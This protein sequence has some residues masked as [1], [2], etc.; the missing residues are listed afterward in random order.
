M[1]RAAYEPEPE[2]GWAPDDDDEDIFGD[3]E[4]DEDDGPEDLDLDDSEF[5]DD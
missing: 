1:A 3:I 2:T 4:D 5:D